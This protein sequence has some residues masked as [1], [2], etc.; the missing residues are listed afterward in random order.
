[1]VLQAEQ[2]D[3]PRPTPLAEPDTDLGPHQAYAFQWWAGMVAAF[4]L[5]YFGAR[6]EYLDEATPSPVGEE[7]AASTPR[8]RKVRVW[9]EEDE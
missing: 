5:V 6:R 3:P 9:D 2:G 4:A 8:P 1:M 7:L